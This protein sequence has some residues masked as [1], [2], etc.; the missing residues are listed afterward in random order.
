MAKKRW[1]PP[2]LT[3]KIQAKQ[4]A[5]APPLSDFELAEL[6]DINPQLLQSEHGHDRDIDT[7]M[8]GLSLAFNDLKDFLWFYSRLGPG[9]QHYPQTPLHPQRGQISGMTLRMMRSIATTLH[10]LLKL[11]EEKKHVTQYERFKSMLRPL[12][13]DALK[14]WDELNELARGSSKGKPAEGSVG[15]MLKSIRDK[16]GSHY[17]VKEIQEGFAEHF[18]P[19]TG[20]PTRD[21]AYYSDGENMERTRFHFADAAAEGVF[22]SELGLTRKQFEEHVEA[23]IG[24]VNEVLKGVINAWLHTRVRSN[25]GQAHAGGTANRPASSA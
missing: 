25:E 24:H 1:K 3:A 17:A 22:V 12:D 5:K 7:L 20:D 10:E 19:N 18:K 11:L 2:S 23:L 13:P 9:A 21:R 16:T 6:A 14:R 4:R 8:L 15:A